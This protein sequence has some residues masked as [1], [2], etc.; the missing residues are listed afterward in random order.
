MN[1]RATLLAAAGATLLAVVQMAAAQSEKRRV[2][3][4][5]ISSPAVGAFLQHTVPVL[6]DLGWIEGDNLILDVRW[7]YGD[8][9]RWAPLTRELLALRPDVFIATLDDMV[10]PAVAAT[11]TVPIVF[12][13]GKDPVA[14]HL[15]K[16]LARPGGNVTGFATLDI[17][18]DPKRLALLKE[19]VPGLTKVGVIVSRA[20][21]LSLDHLV[22]ARNSL[23]I[24]LVPALVEH[25]PNVEAAFEKF[26]KAGVQGVID[27]AENG[28]TYL[29]R[30][31]IAALAIRY[32]MA[33]SGLA[34]AWDS[35]VLM[36]YGFDLSAL[37]TKAATLIDRIL[38]GA[39]PADI[40]VEQI[41]EYELTLNLRTARALG[42]ELPRPLILQATRVIE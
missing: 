12:I 27:T 30:Q 18:L 3:Y 9:S 28:T 36:T 38:K 20:D 1:R 6:R 8:A 5:G 24:E 21:R 42:I 19:A 40:P 14:R 2:A 33:M 13:I 31:R 26:A 32:R 29:E 10:E 23:G 41:S 11:R 16:T 35:G 22:A 25:A 39:R 4:L 37:F 34:A 17:Q 15:V 7:A